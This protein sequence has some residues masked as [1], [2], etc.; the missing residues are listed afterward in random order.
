MR[1]AVLAILFG[2]SCLAQ[3]AL[4]QDAN[5]QQGGP[6]DLCRE[7]LAFAEKKASEPPKQEQSQA[8][9]PA[10][11]PKPR[12]DSP[13]G[14]TQGG[15]SV[16]GSASKDTSSQSSAPPTAPVSSGAAP[17]AASSPHATDSRSSGQGAT[18][19]GAAVPKD[20]FKLAGDIPVKQ[21]RD[22]AQQGDRQACR[23]LAQKVRRAGGD[24]PA[25]LIALAAYEPDPAKRK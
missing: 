7:F 1:S 11:A 13:S 25:A 8:A 4:A 9:A 22:V 16:S 2:A 10:S 20:E 14:G 18:P 5:T 21:V 24:M 17:E 15:G 3:P 6:A 12:T 23:D 19:A